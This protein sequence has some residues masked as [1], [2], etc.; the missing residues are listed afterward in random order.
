LAETEQTAENL[1]T[2]LTEL[3]IEAGKTTKRV[4][5]LAGQLKK[6]S[7]FLVIAKKEEAAMTLKV[8]Y[9]IYRLMTPK[10]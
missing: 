7:L 10:V 8:R 6:I 9:I 1:S 4:S 3:S 5:I 2:A